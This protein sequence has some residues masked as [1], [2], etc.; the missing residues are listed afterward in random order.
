MITMLPAAN[1]LASMLKAEESD[2][3]AIISTHHSLFFN[4]LCNEFKSANKFFIKKTTEG[5]LLKKKL[6]IHL[7][8]SF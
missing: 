4:V 1:H 3:K 6:P 5:Y 8:I 2:V 7:Y